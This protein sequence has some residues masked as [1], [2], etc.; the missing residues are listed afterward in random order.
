MNSR[1]T[2]QL[3]SAIAVDKSDNI[4]VLGSIIEKKIVET[5]GKSS[6]VNIPVGVQCEVFNSKGSKIRDLKLLG[7]VTATGARVSQ[8]NLLVADTK[9]KS[10]VI[11]D[12]RTGA[13][14]IFN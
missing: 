11:F 9:G 14:N 12:T 8:K 3:P 4:F 13:K 2:L 5:R 1:Q 7:V 6:M 10:I